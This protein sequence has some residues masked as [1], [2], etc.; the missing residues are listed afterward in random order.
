MHGGSHEAMKNLSCF[1]ML[2]FLFFVGITP[3]VF[4]DEEVETVPRT[5]NLSFGVKTKR[6]FNSHTSYEFGNPFP[7][8]QEPLS[9][10][11]FPL[12]SWW[13]GG[14]L[15]ANFRRFSLGVEVLTN[16]TG[17]AEGR[18]KD[19]DWDDDEIPSLKTIYSE[20]YCNIRSSYMIT[21][22][23]SLE[24]SDLVGLPEWLSLR[25]V[26]GFRW[27]DLYFVTHDGIQYEIS[28]PEPCPLPG[29]GISFTQRYWQYLVGL[30]SEMDVGSLV[31]VTDL[32]FFL[33]FD[34]AYVEGDNEDHHLLRPGNRF[35]YEDT[36]GDAWHVSAGIK[37]SL[38]KSLFLGVE[39]D[40]LRIK[41][42]GNH[43]LVNDVFDLY[44]SMSKGVTVWSE[45]MSVSLS[46]E[47]RF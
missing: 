13:F 41:T 28:Q 39:A 24:V 18:M 27:H 11:E 32:K 38:Y 20:S 37:K 22:D 5:H 42:S 34:W 35:T 25:P 8:Y 30:R 9:R 40:Y 2:L 7:P 26:M 31:D 17:D 19:S 46:L 23:M 44:Y 15:K 47:Y 36:R 4:A 10:L 1:V 43:R 45:Q 33:Q 16:V 3:P 12:D 21:A 29:D 6:L 14:E